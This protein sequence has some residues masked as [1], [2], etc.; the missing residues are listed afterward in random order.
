MFKLHA[1]SH[2]LGLCI[3][4]KSRAKVAMLPHSR[5][6]S[7]IRQANRGKLCR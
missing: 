5:D 7:G 3:L 6:V 2:L 4:A 1:Y